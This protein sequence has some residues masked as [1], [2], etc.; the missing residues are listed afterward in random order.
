MDQDTSAGRLKR[1]AG[2]ARLLY[3]YGNR[4]VVARAGLSDVLAP[5]VDQEPAGDPDAASVP[6]R[7]AAD[8]EAMGPAYVKL[9]QLLSTRSDLLPPA[10]LEALAR[11]QDRVEPF[12]FADVE[13]LV[14]EEL[15]VRLSKGFSS[16]SDVP[17]A[18]ASLGQVHRATLRDGREVAVKVQRPEAREQVAGDLAAFAHVAEFLDKHTDVGRVASFG[19]IVEEFRRTILEELDYRREAQNLVTLRRNLASFRRLVIPAPIADYSTG[20]VLTMEYVAGTKITALNPV[21]HLDLDA[22]RLVETLFRA[23]LKQIILDGFFHAD[24]HPGNVLIT[25]EGRLALIDLGMVSRLSPRRQEDLLKLLLAVAEGRGEEAAEVA[26]QIGR[27]TERFDRA[28]TEQAVSALVTQY[29]DATLRDVQVGAV[30]LQMSRIA[31]GHGLRLPS[32]L[33]M[34]GKTLLNLDEVARTLAPDFQVHESIRRNAG[35]LMQKRMRRSLSLGGTFSS[36]MELR[37]FA[38]ALPGR[39]NRVL[40]AVSTNEFKIKMEVIDEGALIEG[41]QKVANR[42]ALGVVLAALIVGAAMLMQV[43][44]SFMLFGYPGL[45]ILLFLGAA[46][47]GIWMVVSIMTGD[48]PQRTQRLKP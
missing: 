40:D 24:P 44:T 23:Y 33:A 15:G 20:R 5:H 31:G 26:L 41:F 45:A 8:L 6:K 29:Q 13:R 38:S 14:Q 3:K 16:F 42:I 17:I 37:A 35:N 43:R 2:M 39:L 22:H 1:Y 48:R 10:Y 12:A 47:G 27:K 34:L 46:I 7:L 36:L 32:E 28:A 4:D 11:L 9:G 19:E 30:M 18:A 25:P 21:V